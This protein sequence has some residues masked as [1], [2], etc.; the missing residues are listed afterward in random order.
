M[1]TSNRPDAKRHN[2]SSSS[3]LEEKNNYVPNHKTL[4]LELVA[5][6]ILL[7]KHS[8]WDLAHS[9][10]NGVAITS[11]SNRGEAQA[12]RR[13][14]VKSKSVTTV[15]TKLTTTL[16]G[17]LT[18]SQELPTK[19]KLIL[20][21]NNNTN[22][23]EGNDGV[24]TSAPDKALTPTTTTST[25][26]TIR[27]LEANSRDT[28]SIFAN[29]R[30]SGRKKLQKRRQKD[31]KFDVSFDENVGE[32]AAVGASTSQ[33][34]HEPFDESYGE[35]VNRDANVKGFI[36]GKDNDPGQTE[37]ANDV[38]SFM[39]G[40]T[41]DSAFNFSVD[42][43]AA[44]KSFDEDS[45][46]NNIIKDLISG[47]HI[48]QEQVEVT[49]ADNSYWRGFVR[50]FNVLGS[51][52]ADTAVDPSISVKQIKQEQIE[53]TDDDNVWKEQTFV[54]GSNVSGSV[55]TATAV[56]PSGVDFADVNTTTITLPSKCALL[57][58]H[59]RSTA[60]PQ[61]DDVHSLPI[62]SSQL[63]S[64]TIAH[65]ARVQKTADARSSKD[66]NEI[67]TSPAS[68][69]S[70]QQ[71]QPKIA[72]SDSPASV[73]SVATLP[74]MN[75][76]DYFCIPIVS[77]SEILQLL[78][79][80][81]FMEYSTSNAMLADGE[82]RNQHLSNDV[83]TILESPTSP[84][85]TMKREFSN[86]SPTG[87]D[88]LTRS[89]YHQVGES[90]VVSEGEE[91]AANCDKDD[92]V[93]TWNSFDTQKTVNTCNTS[94]VSSRR[95]RSGSITS[96]KI[97]R[98][99]FENDNKED[100]RDYE[101]VAELKSES[102]GCWSA[103]GESI[104]GV[105]EGEQSKDDANVHSDKE[106]ANIKSPTNSYELSMAPTSVD[107]I[108]WIAKFFE[109]C[110]VNNGTLSNEMVQSLTENKPSPL[111]QDDTAKE[112]LVDDQP[113]KCIHPPKIYRNLK[114]ID[115]FQAKDHSDFS[116]SRN[117]LREK[118]ANEDGKSRVEDINDKYDDDTLETSTVDSTIFTLTSKETAESSS[119]HTYEHVDD[120]QSGCNPIP[121]WVDNRFHSVLDVI[122]KVD[123]ALNRC[124]TE[125]NKNT[126]NDDCSDAPYDEEE[127]D[128]I[129]EEEEEEEDGDD[130]ELSYRRNGRKSW[131]NRNGRRSL[132][133]RSR[134]RHLRRQARMSNSASPSNSDVERPNEVYVSPDRK[135]KLDGT[136]GSCGCGGTVL[137]RNKSPKEHISK[138]LSVD[139]ALGAQKDDISADNA[140]KFGSNRSYVQKKRHFRIKRA[141]SSTS[142][143][144]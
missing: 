15:A 114:P 39:A 85:S 121:L 38:N 119:V 120:S 41:F 138:T 60:S 71:K 139:G 8:E 33:Q 113:L 44:D 57:L 22:N 127:H 58:T 2:A 140:I 109:K 11:T 82:H 1:P 65:D 134:S 79:T 81:S 53:V 87:V 144:L 56:N 4:G 141:W 111:L 42:G 27:C 135:N 31:V 83:T 13:T 103:C 77:S 64:P 54:G 128:D 137:E 84:S 3:P 7:A 62:L 52:A 21:G 93:A 123:N 5:S 133:H 132:H 45:N 115:L 136:F 110:F 129:E 26:M 29:A 130:K 117:E 106:T 61:C 6:E 102:S 90:N 18:S 89:E 88:E 122:D 9:N 78:R 112:T 25:V 72:I 68:I 75:V 35:G 95:R 126:A 36:F 125:C 118:S 23:N 50:G 99:H 48:N 108:D 116:V 101:R 28:P 73:R 74:T 47:K 131:E 91:N 49:N 17:F 107:L 40:Q 20:D 14:A 70:Q 59:D 98:V 32:I 76:R 94:K 19:K 30:K 105:Q 51:G 43:A 12:Q 104:T 66:L 10:E 67:E 86:E 92:D 97:R 16:R 96:Q 55:A 142:S 124:T 69:D 34:K 143:D 80:D 24:V 100:A 63:K 37:V 46:R